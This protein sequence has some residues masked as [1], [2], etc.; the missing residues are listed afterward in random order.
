MP[1]NNK[2]ALVTGASRGV[3]RAVAFA[4][5]Q[6]GANVV[7]TGRDNGALAETQELLRE[8]TGKTN[9][10]PADLTDEDSIKHLVKQ[11]ETQWQKLDILVN[12]AG[13]SFSGK[14]EQTT[15][16]VWDNCHKVNARAA[17]IL[18]RESLPL[19]RQAQPGYII[20]ISSVV[21][22]KG[23]A[24]QVA[25]TASKHALRGMSIALA[26]ELKGEDIRVHVICPGGIDTE[27]VTRIRPDIKKEELI[28][29]EEIAELVLY[30]VTHRGKAIIDELRVRRL[31]SSPWF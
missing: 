27:M 13:V 14:I 20:N 10:I 17:F 7:L 26:E 25:Y 22:I 30:L 5:A 15:T 23:Y 12:N 2:V 1:L 21:G 29:P 11:I 9:V 18:C 4:L 31:S 3:G 8:T 19:L 24:D 6:A 28:Q 16:A